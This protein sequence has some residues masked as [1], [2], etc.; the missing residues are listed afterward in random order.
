[1][2]LLTIDVDDRGVA[3]IVVDHP[4]INLMTFEVLLELLAAAEGLAVDDDVRA[5]VVRSANPEWFIAHFDVEAILALPTDLGSSDELNVFD[6]T[7][8][9]LRTMT[10]PTV[11]VIEGRA[12]GGGSELA[13]ACD[14]RFATPAAVLNQPEVALGIIPGGGGTVR[15]PRLI[16]RSRALETVLGCGDIDA[17]TAERWGWINRVLDGDEI[18]PFVDR[19]TARIAAFPPDAVAA[20]KAS[21]LA[22]EGDVPDHL[23]RESGAFNSLLASPISRRAMERFLERGGQTPA[24]E[25]RLADL[26][27]ELADD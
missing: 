9:L 1:M 17:H 10:K 27:G 16:G 6:R 26:V 21:V 7:C 15:L 5:V 20:A 13:L 3:T 11:A 25:R 12:G 14:M 22:A 18:G 23:R 19:L 8:E 4:P 24:G 2:S